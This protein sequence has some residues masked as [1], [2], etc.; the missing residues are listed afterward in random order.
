MK[1]KKAKSKEG[2]W[3]YWIERNRL[4]ING[5][6]ASLGYEENWRELEMREGLT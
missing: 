3:E 1:D 4:K 2:S 5:I 6:K